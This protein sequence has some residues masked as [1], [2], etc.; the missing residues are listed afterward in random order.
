MVQFLGRHTGQ[1]QP[2]SLKNALAHCHGSSLKL[3]FFK[4]KTILHSL[5]FLFL[6]VNYSFWYMVIRPC[7]RSSLL[8]TI[9]GLIK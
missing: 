7:R 6:V 1:P 5:L 3:A 4:K 8:W 9:D 2:T